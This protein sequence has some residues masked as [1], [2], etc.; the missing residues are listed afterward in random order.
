MG[1]ARLSAAFGRVIRRHRVENGMTQ[2]NLAEAADLHHTYVSLIERGIANITLDAAQRLA[3]ALKTSV[4][5]LVRE[6][7]G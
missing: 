6:A 4:S 2:E 3:R 5:I 1:R 7:E